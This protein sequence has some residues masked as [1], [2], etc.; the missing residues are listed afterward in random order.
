MN[1]VVFV[2]KYVSGCA[3]SP[4][5][6][7]V[8]HYLLQDVLTARWTPLVIHIEKLSER[9]TLRSTTENS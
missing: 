4:S 5:A 6:C 7:D 9:E 8:G 3:K 2:G 1:S